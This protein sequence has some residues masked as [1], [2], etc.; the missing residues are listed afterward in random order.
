[1]A[2]KTNRFFESEKIYVNDLLPVFDGNASLL[3]IRNKLAHGDGFSNNHE[4]L[5]AAGEHLKVLLERVVVRCLGGEIAQTNAG[6]AQIMHS[7]YF[8]K[9]RVNDLKSKLDIMRNS[10]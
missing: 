7:Y 4:V 2:S 3:N 8:S 1:M 10:D 9:D 6:I 5:I